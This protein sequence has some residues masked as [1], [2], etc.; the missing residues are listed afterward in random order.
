MFYFSCLL[1]TLSCD[2]FTL[3]LEV[4]H[5]FLVSLFTIFSFALIFLP[6]QRELTALMLAAKNGH[7]DCVRLLLERG[8]NAKAASRVRIIPLFIFPIH[9]ES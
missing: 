4:D 7:S 2:D 5:N 3:I 6:M 9:S 8:A 1:L